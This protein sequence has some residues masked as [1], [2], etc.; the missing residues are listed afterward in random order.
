MNAFR[1]MNL[2]LEHAVYL[3]NGPIHSKAGDPGG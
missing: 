2:A 3:E 1:G